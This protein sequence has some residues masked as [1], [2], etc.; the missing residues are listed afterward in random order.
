MV[1]PLLRQR[2][3]QRLNDMPLPDHGVEAAWAVFSCEDH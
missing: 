2:V 3:A 1:K